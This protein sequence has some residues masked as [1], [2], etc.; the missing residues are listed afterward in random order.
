MHAPAVVA[1]GDGRPQISEGVMVLTVAEAAAI[2]RVSE[3]TI[4]NAIRSG[5]LPALRLGTG[6]KSGTYRILC[7]DFEAFL[8]WS[9]GHAVIEPPTRPSVSRPTAF[10]HVDVSRWLAGQSER[11]GRRPNGRTAPSLPRSDA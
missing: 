3:N 8:V 7:E 9:K 6:K 4:R 5:L 2:L 10:R 11:G 1:R